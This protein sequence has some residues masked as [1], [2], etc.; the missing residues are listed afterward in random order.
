[1]LDCGGVGAEPV[2]ASQR[3]E[4]VLLGIVLRSAE[5]EMLNHGRSRAAP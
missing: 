5:G 4:T 2:I 3:D 1:V